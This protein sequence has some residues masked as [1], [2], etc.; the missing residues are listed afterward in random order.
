MLRRRGF[1]NITR[2]GLDR[3]SAKQGY[4]SVP[5]SWLG[6]DDYAR[7]WPPPVPDRFARTCSTIRADARAPD[8]VI[9]EFGAH[10]AQVRRVEWLYNTP[11]Q[12]AVES[13]KASNEASGIILADRK[14]YPI[15]ELPR[16]FS[17]IVHSLSSHLKS[18]GRISRLRVVWRSLASKP[19]VE[20]DF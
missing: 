1:P 15:N 3:P 16:G 7:Q 6:V 11:R 5:T 9:G 13:S 14:Q 19:D 18:V 4:L 2:F 20:G 17:S 12:V 10:W 8:A